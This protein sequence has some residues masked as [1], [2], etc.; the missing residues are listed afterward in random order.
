MIL[1]DKIAQI[2][3]KGFQTPFPITIL[4]SENNKEVVLRAKENDWVIKY[5][6]STAVICDSYKEYRYGE[7]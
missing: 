1:Y 3:V 2:K 5:K 6:D 7:F 4:T